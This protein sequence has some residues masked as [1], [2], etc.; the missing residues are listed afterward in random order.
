M[1]RFTHALII[2]LSIILAYFWLR[3]PDL[4]QYTP[5]IFAFTIIVYF[6]AKRI[7]KK[8]IWHI[9]P[10]E[11]SWEMSLATFSFLLI[12][13]YTGNLES[14]IYPLAFV[15]L[16][17]LILTSHSVTAIIAVLGITLFHYALTPELSV[18]ELSHLISIPLV[19]VFFLFAK[20]QY[21]Q[22]WKERLIIREEE[23][24][25]KNLKIEESAFELFLQNF[26]DEKVNLIEQ[27]ANHP[28]ENKKV[29]QDQIKLAKQNLEEMLTYLEKKHSKGTQGVHRMKK[30]VG[31]AF[32]GSTIE[33]Q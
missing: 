8:K 15:H 25:I 9:L 14:I 22:A 2:S 3:T 17:F 24:E 7:K 29:L 6:I 18:V 16:F 10:E 4:S 30:R 11:S 21:H 1:S 33:N 27:L 13:G 31:G 28:Q 5:Q 12:I 32:A 23:A 26:I 20:E 19:S